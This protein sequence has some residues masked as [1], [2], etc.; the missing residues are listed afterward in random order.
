MHALVRTAFNQGDADSLAALYEPDAVLVIDGRKV[1]GRE[2]IHA[3]YAAILRDG[4]AMTLV[5]RS[6]VETADL[7]V[8]HG[9]WIVEYASGRVTR[10]VS[11]EVVRKQID[12][13]WLFGIDCPDSPAAAREPASHTI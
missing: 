8:L 10:G 12:G 11:C 4:A 13:T 3:A 5:T 7:A 1:I 2:N 6:L 9:D